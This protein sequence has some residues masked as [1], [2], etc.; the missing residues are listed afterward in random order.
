MNDSISRNLP[1]VTIHIHVCIF[2]LDTH[3]SIIYNWKQPKCSSVRDYLDIILVQPY[4]ET[5]YS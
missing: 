4:Y 3:C 1:Y 2:I 5:L